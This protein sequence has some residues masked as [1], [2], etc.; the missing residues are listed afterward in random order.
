MGALDLDQRVLN[1][2]QSALGFEAIQHLLRQSGDGSGIAGTAGAGHAGRLAAAN[3]V[4]EALESV[5]AAIDQASSGRQVVIGQ[6]G[7]GLPAL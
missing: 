3:G 1:G 6:P 4:A 2:D 5:L 7:A